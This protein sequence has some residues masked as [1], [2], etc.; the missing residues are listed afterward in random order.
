MAAVERILG[1]LGLAETPRLLVMNKVDL[2]P[3]DQREAVVRAEGGPDAIAVS[4]R[5]RHTTGPLLAAVELAL[6]KEGRLE[7]RDEITSVA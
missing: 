3:P 6:W 2:I 5:D 4:A 7:R 1:D